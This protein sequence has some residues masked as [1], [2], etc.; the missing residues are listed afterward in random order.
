MARS[1]GDIRPLPASCGL[2]S[3][4]PAGS[5]RPRSPCTSVCFASVLAAPRCTNPR[6]ALARTR[7]RSSSPPPA[8]LDRHV[9]FDAT[10]ATTWSCGLSRGCAQAKVEPLRLDSLTTDRLQRLGHY[11]SGPSGG[12]SGRGSEEAGDSDSS[13]PG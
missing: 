12:W 2:S 11:G 6:I 4:A 9:S 3:R 7:R 5:R 10:I 13:S 1:R 8:Y